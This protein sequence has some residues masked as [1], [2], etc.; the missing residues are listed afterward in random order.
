MT[1][2][3]KTAAEI[4]AERIAAARSALS[5]AYQADPE[6]T[7]RFKARMAHLTA[8][9]K[10]ERERFE[11]KCLGKLPDPPPVGPRPK[12]MSR[13]EWKIEK[14]NRQHQARTAQSLPAKWSHKQGTP[15]TL[16]HASRT[17]QGAL[18]QLHLNGTISAEQLEWAAQ[19]DN[20]HRS[21]ESDVAVA[22]ASLEARVDQSH[23]HDL[24][25]E[26]IRRIRLHHAY[27]IWRDGLPSPKRLVLDMLVGEPIGYTVAARR[28]AIHNRRAKRL[29]IEAIDRW[30]DCVSMAYR[31]VTESDVA[32]LNAA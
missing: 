5:A 20:V 27:T 24:A 19:I 10:R 7:E 29:L 3:E 28:Y 11:T 17:H 1:K 25:I 30:P 16:E 8:A 23:R 12:G 6:G 15:E 4:R 32:R 2:T 31:I 26:S 18:A 22:V 14:R 9:K 13:A 21:I